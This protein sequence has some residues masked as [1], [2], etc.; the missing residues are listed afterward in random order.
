MRSATAAITAG[1]TSAS[2]T[3]PSSGTNS[4][5]STILYTDEAAYSS[6]NDARLP[7]HGLPHPSKMKYGATI[8]V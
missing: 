1:I 7:A 5:T 6:R 8:L 3:I 4:F 2:I